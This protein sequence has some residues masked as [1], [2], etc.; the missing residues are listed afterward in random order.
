MLVDCNIIII[1]I[2]FIS[3]F[4]FQGSAGYYGDFN[5]DLPPATFDLL[6][7]EVKKIDPDIIF[8]AGK[9]FHKYRSSD[10][11]IAIVYLKQVSL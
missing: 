6:L 10:M 8:Y 9:T 3:Q 1:I 4:P 7:E 2:L 5:C 11:T